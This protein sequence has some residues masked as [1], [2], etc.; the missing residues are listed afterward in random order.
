MSNYIGES[1]RR[2][3]EIVKDHDARDTKSHV[4]KIS[5]ENKHVEVIQE[6][7]KINCSHFWNNRLK[8]KTAEAIL[9]KQELPTL[10][11]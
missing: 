3:I 8:R 10:N 11:I 7:F 4:F 5:R 2:I 6:D 1:A 9:I